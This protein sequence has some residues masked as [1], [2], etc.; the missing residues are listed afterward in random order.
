MSSDSPPQPE[1]EVEGGGGVFLPASISLT[2]QGM[3]SERGDVSPW[4]GGGVSSPGVSPPPSYLPLKCPTCARQFPVPSLL[5][6]HMRTHTNERPYQC[7]ICGRSYSQSGNL[8]VHMKTIH[9]VAEVPAPGGQTR[10]RADAEG[11]RPHKC[12]I[13]NRLFTTS[14]N[15]Y[16][17]VRVVHNIMIETSKS[18]RLA[19]QPYT[20]PSGGGGMAVGVSSQPLVPSKSSPQLEHWAQVQLNE[21]KSLSSTEQSLPPSPQVGVGRGAVGGSFLNKVV[22]EPTIQDTLQQLSALA[23]GKGSKGKQQ[24]NIYMMDQNKP[25]TPSA[26]DQSGARIKQEKE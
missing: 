9:G 14:S 18:P 23:G 25:I 24:S 22:Q 13:C 6:R 26:E 1:S 12:Y 17:H 7:R 2:P 21:L 15:M 3:A 10:A 19:H 5:E 11:L 8:N 20:S 16:Q 4:G